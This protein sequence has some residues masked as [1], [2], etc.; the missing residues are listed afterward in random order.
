MYLPLFVSFFHSTF[1]PH[2]G[3]KWIGL[4][5]AYAT[6]IF[7]IAPGTRPP[8]SSHGSEPKKLLVPLSTTTK[9]GLW[10]IRQFPIILLLLLGIPESFFFLK[11]LL[12]VRCSVGWDL[13]KC[14]YPPRLSWWGFDL[15]MLLSKGASNDLSTPL[16]CLHHWK[17]SHLRLVKAFYHLWPLLSNILFLL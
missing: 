8:F 13:W 14:V 15:W 17:W 12:L 10:C 11:F 2:I 3:D 6:T 7:P 5:G 4:I 16:P 9:C 1:L